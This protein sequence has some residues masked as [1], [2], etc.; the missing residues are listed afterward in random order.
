MKS[1]KTMK[2]ALGTSILAMV[3]C[4]AML[5][6][7]TMAW[8]TDSVAS[9]NNII[10][11]GNLDIEL[12]YAVLNDDGSF[13]EWKDVKDSTEIFDK[14]AQWEPGH[15]EVAYLK[16]SN[17]GSLALKYNLGMNI[18]SETEGTN[19]YDEKFYLS[20]FIKYDAIDDVNGETSAYA[21]REAARDAVV[22]D[23][24]LDTAFAQ[25]GS[26]KAGEVKYLAI[27]V[28]MPTTVDNEANFKTGTKIPT[29]NLGI[30]VV[31]TQVENESDAFDNTYDKD[32]HKLSQDK[33]GAY[34]IY[35]AKDLMAVKN[36]LATVQHGEGNAISFELMA[37]VDMTGYV[38]SPIDLHWASFDGN[39]H[40]I[41]NLNC[42]DDNWAYRSGFAAYVGAGEITNL[43]LKNVVA[44]GGQVGIFAGH[45]ESGDIINCNIAGTNALVWTK[46][47][48]DQN[49]GNGVGIYAG[50]TVE[51]SSEYSGTIFED[52]VIVV[53]TD[54]MT[55]SHNW[56][57]TDYAGAHFNYSNPTVNVTDLRPTGSTTP[58]VKLD[59]N[60]GL[61]WNGQSGNHK[62]V[63][64]VFNAADLQKAVTWFAGQSHSNEANTVKIELMNDIDM[65][66]VDWAPW[67]VMFLTLNGNNHTIS[68]LSNSLFG[69]AGAVNVNDLTLE[70]V[71]SKSN[72]AGTFA[73]STEGAK[74]NN[75]VLKG[76][77]TV[78][79]VD[80]GK[81][82]NGIGA[83]SG[84]T[85]TST[86]NVTI[87]E[88]A[89]VIIDK[90][91]IV[92]TEKTT[93]ESNL[94]GY[95]H[96]TY[97][98]NSGTIVNNGTLKIMVSTTAGLINEIKNAPTGS[99]TE[100]ILA[101]GT[102][103]GN[104]DITLAA[105]GKQA[106]DVV[107]K[108]AEGAEPV[109][110]G[111]VTLGYREQTVGATMYK[112]NVTFDGI[113][114]DHANA[115]TH[116]LDVQDVKSLTL[117]NC[118]I[119]GDGEYGI[120]SARGNATGASKIVDCTFIN[121]GAQLLGNFATGLVIDDCT[122][123]NSRVN[124]PAGTSVTIQNCEFTGTLT[125]ANVNDSFYFV[126][127]N[128]TPIT[129]KDC[130]MSVDSTVTGVAASQAKWYL[131]ANRGTTNWT[132]ENVA[133]TL[134]P[135]A[136]A[137]TELD[138]TACTSTGVINTTNLTVNGVVQ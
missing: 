128:S 10:K 34:L 8:F 84:V 78:T 6:G 103:E 106:G 109:I 76:T 113:T 129:V 53:S 135:A 104:I 51:T 62:G 1:V 130:T 59:P 15:T 19:V 107:I 90:G 111:T 55:N 87:D 102:Y 11:S 126:R 37:D 57:L 29:I 137:Q 98:T 97:A 68:N 24:L 20:D 133:V 50:I 71:T 3:L 82:E 12:E 17:V 119:I 5:A 4:V 89:V 77:N 35:D 117:K 41:S 63:Y 43:T 124:V 31:A 52:T 9:A 127:S 94:Y 118:T 138:V 86:L 131:M 88:N 18:A 13:K 47:T 70:N 92:D 21:N 27:V 48:G 91:N 114:F 7:T 28:Y 74:F 73:S 54:G 46:E 64:Y 61:I 38:W 44:K 69:Y 120:T 101:D 23:I 112:A 60:S 30:N 95:K 42:A 67:S 96:T 22:E 110:A 83:I 99:V 58:D 79:Y 40:T 25:S 123:N 49:I 2:R 105:M 65:T 100:I 93:F 115:A 136:L 72:Q 132:V 122:F 66:G 32:A 125:D 26:L 108:A 75:C 14:N 56:V 36:I 134:T 45:T 33:N 16:V 80:A 39:G 81:N 116:S 121:A 85:I